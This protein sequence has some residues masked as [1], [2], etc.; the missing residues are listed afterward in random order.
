KANYYVERNNSTLFFHSGDW[1]GPTTKAA[2]ALRESLVEAPWEK[3]R[4]L[5]FLRAYYLA[6]LRLAKLP[7][8]S[9]NMYTPWT[10][11]VLAD[12]TL[13]AKRWRSIAEEF[14]VNWPMLWP[15]EFA[16]CLRQVRARQIYIALL[17]Y[18]I[19]HG[20]PAAKLEDL[21]PRYLAAVPAD[22]FAS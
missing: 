4:H 17:L 18:Q 15:S 14:E 13:P 16:P 21:V 20:R 6:Q 1:Q 5:R 10:V 22:P 11:A 3:E 19:D 9:W 8:G 2:R 7:P 12:A